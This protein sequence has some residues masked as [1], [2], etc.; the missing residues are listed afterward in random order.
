MN[1][2]RAVVSWL[3]VAAV[4]TFGAAAART[5]AQEPGNGGLSVVQL[6]ARLLSHRR[7]GGNIVRRPGEGVV[8]VDSVRRIR[9]IACSRNRRLTRAH[10]AHHQHE[11]K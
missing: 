1:S 3:A 10:F 4:L 5:A 9:R 11:R 7:A 2:T 6:R 8:V